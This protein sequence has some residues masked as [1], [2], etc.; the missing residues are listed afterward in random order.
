MSLFSWGSGV[1]ADVAIAEKTNDDEI[2]LA[3]K[4]RGNQSLV[5]LIPTFSEVFRGESEIDGGLL[6]ADQIERKLLDYGIKSLPA[7]DRYLAYLPQYGEANKGS[8]QASSNSIL[9]AGCYVG[10]VIRRCAS[11]EY[12]WERY[13]SSL[14]GDKFLKNAWHHTNRKPFPLSVSTRKVLTD[15]W[16]LAPDAIRN[17]VHL[18]HGGN[19][20]IGDY[21]NSPLQKWISGEVGME[22]VLISKTGQLIQPLSITFAYICDRQMSTT[23]YSQ[24]IMMPSVVRRI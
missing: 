9:A 20:N 11:V 6:F 15:A 12:Y 14:I 18:W 24:M 3:V 19:C 2:L 10:E 13:A 8:R 23:V 17:E 5:S 4:T 22:P 1:I 21:K 7:V 16:N